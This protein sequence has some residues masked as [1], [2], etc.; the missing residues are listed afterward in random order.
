M[1]AS[2][3]LHLHPWQPLPLALGTK[4]A[5][6]VSVLFP[7]FGTPHHPIGRRLYI[8]SF[9]GTGV[10]ASGGEERA[11]LGLPTLGSSEDDCRAEVAWPLQLP[12]QPRKDCLGFSAPEHECLF[13]RPRDE[14]LHSV[15]SAPTPSL[16]TLTLSGCHTG[17]SC[18]CLRCR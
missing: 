4:I 13:P 3:G 1:R 10:A 5:F 8:V 15:S 14:D 18:C 6:P 17:G 7:V 2:L 16:L 12:D 11:W 9:A